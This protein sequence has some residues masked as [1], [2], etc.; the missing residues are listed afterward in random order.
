MKALPPTDTK[1]VASPVGI[2]GAITPLSGSGSDS[3]GV[4]SSSMGLTGGGLSSEAGARDVVTQTSTPLTCPSDAK[5]SNNNDSQEHPAVD[6][7]KRQLQFESG[8][9]KDMVVA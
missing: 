7:S 2:S 3:A 1:L 8:M 5:G 6:A 9:K 4:A